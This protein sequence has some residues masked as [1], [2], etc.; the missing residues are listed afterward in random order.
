MDYSY[1]LLTINSEL[2]LL[3]FGLI[4]STI[5]YV[6]LQRIVFEGDFEE[7]QK[8]FVLSMVLFLGTYILR[9]ITTFAIEMWQDTYV[10][11]MKNY[12]ASFITTVFLFHIFYDA[13][14]IV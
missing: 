12:P 10:S 1:A 2:L 11:W 5:V 6:R 7:E 13:F 4:V 9:F 8:F 14:P 3:G